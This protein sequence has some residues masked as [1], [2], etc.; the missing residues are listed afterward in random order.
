MKFFSKKHKEGFALIEI[1]VSMAAGII[2]LVSFVTL[3]MQAK[4]ISRSNSEKLRATLYLREMIEVAK[5][6]ETSN[7]GE[8]LNLSCADP[9]SCHPEIVAGA[10][11]FSA[12]EEILD[13]G[14]FRRSLSVFP[15]YR[16][17]LAFPNEIVTTGGIL[18]PN[19]KKVRADIS[20]L[21]EFG[22]RTMNLETYVHA[23]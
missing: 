14:F 17:Q 12:N 11:K 15:V 23:P 7:W 6:L 21:G 8:L 18:D 1:I 4:K 20:W 9:L 22:A 16:N 3:A 2:I 19:T 10:W 5:D 13:N